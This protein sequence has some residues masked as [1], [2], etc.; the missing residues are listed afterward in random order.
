MFTGIFL[1][2]VSIYMLLMSNLPANKN[3]GPGGFTAE[4]CQKFREKLLK[5]QTYGG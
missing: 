5:T 3:P 4:L 1:I 2:T